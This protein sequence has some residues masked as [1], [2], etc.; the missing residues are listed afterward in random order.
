M[1]RIDRRG[2]LGLT[3][4]AGALGLGGCASAPAIVSS[5]S[6]NGKLRFAAIGCGGEGS[7]DISV[8]ATHR[9]IEMAAFCDVDT[10]MLDRQRAKFPKAQFFQHWREML[11]K[12]RPDAVL[13]ATPDHNH[14]L[15][16]SEVMRRGIHL[17]AQ[18]PLCRTLEEVGQLDRLAA[19]SGVVTQLGTQCAAF[20]YDRQ[21]AAR[22]Q[23][24]A[25]GEVKK[26]WLFSNTG[27]YQKLLK[28]E[29]P[30]E[31]A[32]V[33]ETLDW[34]AWLEGAPYRDYVPNVYHSFRWRAWKDFGSG[35]LGD[36]GSH[37]FSP[38]WLG[39]GMGRSVPTKVTAKVKDE[40][41]DAAKRSQFL[42]M[43]AHLTFTFP[44]LKSTGMKPF[45]VEWCDGPRA[46]DLPKG[47]VPEGDF[48]KLAKARTA[49]T[50][51]EFLPPAKFHELAAKTPI[52][53]LPRQA[54]VIEG[55][56]G[57]MIST[58]CDL[59]PVMLDRNLKPKPLALPEMEPD[60]NHY[61]EFVDC[62]LDGGTPRSSLN[63]TTKLTETIVRGNMAIRANAPA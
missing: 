32:P 44:G 28:R 12:V 4:A 57:W 26:V 36:M 42:P 16:M 47:I 60:P 23:A 40:G 63:W 54:R 6:P 58:H 37:L 53:D 52:G 18:K 50:D 59:P 3:V 48:D 27:V 11:D 8:F 43:C 45:E 46:G 35:W 13:V 30:L 31:A 22:L 39:L 56:E 14:C 5:R 51:P 62:C 10:K 20:E 49:E 2:F 25:I 24:G 34:K 41:W 21:T 33:P 19:S 15:I 55:S 61:H 9:R 38:V 29:W 17:Y 1:E 7:Y